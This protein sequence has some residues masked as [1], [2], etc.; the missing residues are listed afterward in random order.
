M[1]LDI[2][3][4]S[5][6]FNTNLSDNS[7]DDSDLGVLPNKKGTEILNVSVTIEQGI[8]NDTKM[9]NTIRNSVGMVTKDSFLLDIYGDNYQDVKG[10]AMDDTD[11]ESSA[12]ARLS[13][14]MMVGTTTTSHK[15][16]YSSTFKNGPDECYLDF[17]TICYENLSDHIIVP[18]KHRCGC[19]ECLTRLRNLKL[20]C[21]IC[22][23][24]VESISM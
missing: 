16:V 18:C 4:D 3:S 6:L 13:N 19:K 8:T 21:P 24:P 1:I 22:R 17:C 15:N 7:I 20:L 14:Q 2:G 9:L 12:R 5:S 23:G 10:V 11:N